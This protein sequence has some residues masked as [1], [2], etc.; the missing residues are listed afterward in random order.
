MAVVKQIALVCGN[1]SGTGG[2]QRLAYLYAKAVASCGYSVVLIHCGDRV[3]SQISDISGVTTV[4]WH[5][6]ASALRGLSTP[7]PLLVLPDSRARVIALFALRRAPVRRLFIIDSTRFQRLDCLRVRK[8]LTGLLERRI[9]RHHG[10]I[11]TYKQAAANVA[12]IGGRCLGVLY[13]PVDMPEPDLH[14]GPGPTRLVYLGRLEPEKG[15]DR[16]YAICDHLLR[17]GTGGMWFKLDIWGDGS[18][19]NTLRAA[20]ECTPNVQVK[21]PTTSPAEVLATADVVL[22]PS[23]TE[24][25]SITCAEAVSMGVPVVHFTVDGNGPRE[26]SARGGY[27]VPQ[28]DV[29]LF[30]EAVFKA[31]RFSIDER[32]ELMRC[33][34]ARYG[35]RPFVDQL[36]EI[37]NEDNCPHGDGLSFRNS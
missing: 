32:R 2:V 4:P 16:L 13:N 7:I 28:G 24:G 17:L 11:A 36:Q 12:E 25:P 35:F 10:V 21:G 30:A 5:V 18:L 6:H 23:R 9:L 1:L 15:A 26:I 37:I 34:R 8:L 22:L 29:G 3:P 31:A 14:Q 27:E 33:S 20:F 19:L